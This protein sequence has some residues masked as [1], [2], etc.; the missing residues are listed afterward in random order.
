MHLWKNEE[1][2]ARVE[3]FPGTSAAVRTTKQCQAGRGRLWRR[4]KSNAKRDGTVSGV[5]AKVE[6]RARCNLFRD[7]SEWDW[8]K[9]YRVH[10]LK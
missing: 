9:P 5:E 2:S 8:L 3:R 4:S 7:V 6:A 1:H 10:V